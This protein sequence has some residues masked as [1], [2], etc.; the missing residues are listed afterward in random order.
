MPTY[1]VSTKV[2]LFFSIG[3]MKL[4]VNFE[5]EKRINENDRNMKNINLRVSAFIHYRD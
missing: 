3:D 5:N 1:L 2:K 4:G